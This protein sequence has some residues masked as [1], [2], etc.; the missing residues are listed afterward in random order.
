MGYPTLIQPLKIILIIY[1]EKS[2]TI[3]SAL[4]LPI[5]R[6]ENITHYIN[7]ALYMFTKFT[8]RQIE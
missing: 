6:T 8:K 1:T 3:N 5:Y 2:K 7:S 4:Q